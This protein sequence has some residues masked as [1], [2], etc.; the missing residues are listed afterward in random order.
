MMDFFY[1]THLGYSLNF[2]ACVMGGI[3]LTNRGKVGKNRSTRSK[4]TIFWALPSLLIGH[5]PHLVGY[6]LFCLLPFG[7]SP[8][9]L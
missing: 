7:H 9:H 8:S 5:S 1:Y 3:P 6:C 2:T 4:T